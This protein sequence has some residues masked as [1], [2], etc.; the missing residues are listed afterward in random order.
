MV[1]KAGESGLENPASRL[2]MAGVDLKTVQELMRHK[3]TAMTARC[4]HFSSTHKL[5]LLEI[6]ARPG[7]F[8]L[9]RDCNLAAGSKHA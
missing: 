8:S 3:M 4:A 5:Q 2:A 1:S 9:P 7:P 6:A